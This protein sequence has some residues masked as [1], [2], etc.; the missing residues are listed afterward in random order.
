M[1]RWAS[2]ERSYRPVT[3]SYGTEQVDLS[4]VCAI[5]APPP[6]GL[7][8]LLAV[9]QSFS[10]ILSARATVDLRNLH[11]TPLD[12]HNGRQAGPHRSRRGRQQVANKT[13]GLF[14]CLAN[15]TP[16]EAA[17]RPGSAKVAHK[18]ATGNP[19]IR[20]MVPVQCPAVS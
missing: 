9:Q 20:G 8:E 15:D 10:A 16:S 12:V 2:L 19:H 11:S 1:G 5:R 3:L 7:S 4:P 18:S 17:S 14:D 13:G 6:S